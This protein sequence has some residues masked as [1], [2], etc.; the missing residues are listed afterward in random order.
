[1]NIQPSV[2][3]ILRVDNSLA[4]ALSRQATSHEWELNDKYLYLIFSAWGFQD[5]DAFTTQFTTFIFAPEGP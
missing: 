3:H 2:T 4:D 5:L 1:M